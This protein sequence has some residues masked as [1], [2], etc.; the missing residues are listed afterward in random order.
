[1]ES[2]LTNKK[3]IKMEKTKNKIIT[4][5]LCFKEINKNRMY[6]PKYIKKEIIKKSGLTRLHNTYK[7]FKDYRKRLLNKMEI[8]KDY[9][10]YALNFNGNVYCKLYNQ[11]IQEGNLFFGALMIYYHTIAEPFGIK[12]HERRFD[13]YLTGALW[14]CRTEL[15]NVTPRRHW[16]Y[17]DAILELKEFD[18]YIN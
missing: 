18:I 8:T 7:K 4:I 9:L 16:N 14:F 17:L 11:M 3:K 5:L 13:R 12:F 15:R 6:I 1:M 10:Y 2:T